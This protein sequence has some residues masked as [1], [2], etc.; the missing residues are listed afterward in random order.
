MSPIEGALWGLLGGL[1]V[2]ALELAGE[3][4][5]NKNR[6][7]W[8]GRKLWPSLCA[9]VLRLAA[10]SALAAAMSD[11]LTGQWPAFCIGV[12][13]PLA[14]SRISE[15]TPAIAS[16]RDGTEGGGRA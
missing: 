3:I 2:E 6:W 4:R 8:T 1:A 12:G 5:R 9:V 10:S 11:Q 15:Q 14:V 13:A 16:D 7:P